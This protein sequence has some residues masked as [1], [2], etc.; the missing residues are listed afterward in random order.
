MAPPPKIAVGGAPPPTLP[1]GVFPKKK[2]MY[3]CNI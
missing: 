3:F 2:K 1:G